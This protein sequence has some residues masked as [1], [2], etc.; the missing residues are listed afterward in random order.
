MSPDPLLAGGGWA[1][2]YLALA[3]VMKG[4]SPVYMPATGTMADRADE[5]SFEVC[6]EQVTDQQVG[7][8]VGCSCP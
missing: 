6:A 4:L 2:D 7:I 3:L 5:P 1:R 8:C